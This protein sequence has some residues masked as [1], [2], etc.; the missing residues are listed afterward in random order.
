[1][2]IFKNI[3]LSRDAKILLFCNFLGHFAL[4]L[5]GPIYAIFVQHVGGDILEAGIAYAI[6]SISIGIFVFLFGTSKFFADRIRQMVVV[7]YSFLALG[8]LGYIFV[9]NTVQ[10]FII[11]IILGVAIGILDPSWSGIFSAN[12]S[13]KKA[14]KS[15]AIWSG[16]TNIVIGIAAILGGLIVTQFSFKTLFIIMFIFNIASA[17]LSIR[18]LK[19]TKLVKKRGNKR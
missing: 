19:N 14:S 6:Y 9:Q 10:L 1:M 18:I 2:S 12:M 13:E 15:W 11:Q 4:G 3:S 16:S 17:I 8:S 5:L 7:G